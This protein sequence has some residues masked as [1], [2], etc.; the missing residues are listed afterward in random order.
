LPTAEPT[1]E[2]AVWLAASFP[3]PEAIDEKDDPRAVPEVGR[4]RTVFT[5]SIGV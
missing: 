3:T 1:A 5:T 2:A 4:F